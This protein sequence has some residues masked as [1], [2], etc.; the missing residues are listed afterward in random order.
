MRVLVTGANGFVGRALLGPLAAAGHAPIA[1]TRGAG[2]AG[3]EHRMV[4]ALGPATDWSAALAGVDAVVHLAA[5]VHRVGRLAADPPAAYDTENTGGT[6]RLAE[7]AAGA[8]V[9]RLVF[10]STAKVNGESTPPDRPFRDADP[11]DPRDAYAGSKWAAEQ[12][13]AE[14]AA[15]TGLEVTVL[16]PPLVYGPGA[17]GNLRA[18]LRLC[19]SPLPLPFGA[20]D[21]RRSLIYLDN[22]TDVICQALVH[23]A[24]AGGRFLISDAEALSTP[25]L[26]RR[27]RHGLGRPARLV[28]VPPSWLRLAAR[29]PGLGGALDRL[30]QSLVVDPGGI[31]RALG[32]RPRFAADHGL[33]RTAQAYREDSRAFSV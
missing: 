31:A 2:P 20:V 6:R 19:D 27:L 10:V 1:A 12:A 24:A 26:V 22:L 15:D 13:L 8:G 17:R 9:R 18:L 28:A 29:L 25:G 5:R 4:G 14:V 3:V 16:R 32:W 11:A 21:N 7:Q 30:T 33:A 23:P